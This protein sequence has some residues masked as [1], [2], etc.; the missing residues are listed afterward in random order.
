[1]SLARGRVISA[2]Q[3]EEQHPEAR[4][5][6]KANTFC[7]ATTFGSDHAIDPAI[8]QRPSLTVV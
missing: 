6:T 8:I 5:L 2:L 3:P 7:V 4:K 1:M